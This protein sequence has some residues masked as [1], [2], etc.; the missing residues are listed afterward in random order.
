MTSKSLI[1]VES[2]VKAR[3]IQSVLGADEFTVRATLGHFVDL[4]PRELGVDLETMQETYVPIKRKDGS[5]STG[6][7]QTLKSLSRSHSFVY[8]AS[9][10]DREGEAIAEHLREFLHLADNR[11]SKIDIHVITEEGIRTALSNPRKL[12]R[13]LLLAQSS[14]RVLDRLVGDGLSSVVRN[15]IPEAKS[16]GRLQLAGLR[17][18]CDREEEI[19]KFKPQELHAIKAVFSCEGRENVYYLSERGQEHYCAPPELLSDLNPDEEKTTEREQQEMLDS[20]ASGLGFPKRLVSDRSLAGLLS[21]LETKIY[22]VS[23]SEIKDVT[24]GQPKPVITSDM[25]QMASSKL[26]WEP[27]KT[28]QVAQEL[29]RNGW[30]SYHR[31]DSVRIDEKAIEEALTYIGE[32]WGEAYCRK[33]YRQAKVSDA[34]QDA[35]ESIRPTHIEIEVIPEDGVDGRLLEDARKLYVLLRTRFLQVLMSAGINEMCSTEI[36]SNDNEACFVGKSTCVKFDGW[37][38]LNKTGQDIQTSN[39]KKIAVG[40]SA[41]IHEI[42]EDVWETT[43]PARYNAASFVRVLERKEIGRPSTFATVS[44]ILLKRE[45][46]SVGKNK[47]YSP[48]SLGEKVLL[49]FDTDAGRRYI[50]LDYTA[51][52]E[53]RLE[54][55]AKP[56]DRLDF[57]QEVC[58]HLKNNFGAFEKTGGNMSKPTEGQL[59]FLDKITERGTAVPDECYHSFEAAKQYL[60]AYTAQQRPSEAMVEFATKLAASHTKSA[61][62]DEILSSISKTKEFI[63]KWKNVPSD[64]DSGEPPSQKQLDLVNSLSERLGCGIDPERIKTKYLASVYINELMAET[65]QPPSERMLQFA[66]N[67]ADTLGIKFDEGMQRSSRLTSEFITKNKPA[68]EKK[69]KKLRKQGYTN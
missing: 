54:T 59:K 22:T 66:L 3:K 47:R 8:L 9:D 60:N 50:E 30:I 6:L 26:G 13:Q 28:M 52:M 17:I 62:T 41:V 31:T 10:P 48:T 44:Q 7:I 53:K 18:I 19:R 14:R 37:R 32:K 65:E 49:W 12:D 5:D 35:H 4:P 42:N 45:Y 67:I 64:V 16:V 51:N 61:L 15:Q 43:P 23:R 27:D 58:G 39:V 68:F 56:Q 34:A 21:A 55:L 11:F 33:G 2:P 57:L 38:L 40:V 1:I 46:I 20:A 24:V 29:F 25:Q 36:V 69:Q 63:E